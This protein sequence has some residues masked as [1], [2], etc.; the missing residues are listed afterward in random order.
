MRN[1]KKYEL[2]VSNYKV[3]SSIFMFKFDTTIS[4]KQVEHLKKVLKFKEGT[5]E[6][7]EEIIFYSSLM[8]K[9]TPIQI[10]Y[11]FDDRF[12]VWY[13]DD[14]STFADC[15]SKTTNQVKGYFNTQLNN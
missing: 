13:L 12:D 8:T 11:I 6:E 10:G 7:Q 14:S 1:T 5:Y 3:E 4:V 2:P 9:G 15:G